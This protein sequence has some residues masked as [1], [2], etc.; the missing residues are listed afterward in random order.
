MFTG[1]IDL[2]VGICEGG[3]GTVCSAACAV[4]CSGV[5]EAEVKWLR[6]S[7][8]E[9]T[10]PTDIQGSILML[11]VLSGDT[12]PMST[13]RCKPGVDIGVLSAEGMAPLIV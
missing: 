13:L 7:V 2:G 6:I 8:C 11:A 10:S 9:M 1:G 3:A 4:L 12:L 5:D